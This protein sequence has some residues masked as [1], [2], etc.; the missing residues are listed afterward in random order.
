MNDNQ[1]EQFD[2]DDMLDRTGHQIRLTLEGL[3]GQASP[4]TIFSD[5][6]LV[7]DRLVITA[8]AGNEAVASDL[9]LG[10]ATTPRAAAVPAV[11]AEAEVA[12]KGDRWPLSRSDRRE[13]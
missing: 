13:S 4:S 5:P 12:R 6:H 7:G 3:V 9:V 11:V 10:G 2:F 8:A 1:G